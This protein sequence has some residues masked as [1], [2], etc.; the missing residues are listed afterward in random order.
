MT[1]LTR[2]LPKLLRA[3]GGNPEL[4]A[5]LAWG[6]A[7]GPGLRPHAVPVRLDG[8]TLI[9]AVADA[10]WQKQLEH[11]RG[12]IIYR[13]NNLLGQSLVSA[14]VFQIEPSLVTAN[15]KQPEPA[16]QQTQV[17]APEE[18]LFAAGAITDDDLRARFIRAAE[19][20]ISRRDAQGALNSK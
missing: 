20:C 10:I 4:A 1:D 6:R 17:S 9:V 8:S 16:A 5:K 7:A 14:V 2:I 15:Q 11:M 19:S 3:N 12:E 18:L 13:I